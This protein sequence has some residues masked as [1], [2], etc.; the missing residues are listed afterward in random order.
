LGIKEFKFDRIFGP[1]PLGA[2]YGQDL[3]ENFGTI[4]IWASISTNLGSLNPKL[5]IF[6][7]FDNL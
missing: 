2:S 5:A 4:V 1:D 6:L 7:R 3:W